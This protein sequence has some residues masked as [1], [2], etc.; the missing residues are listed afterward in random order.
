MFFKCSALN[1]HEEIKESRAGEY[2]KGSRY[3]LHMGNLG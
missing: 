1:A 3:A 2:L